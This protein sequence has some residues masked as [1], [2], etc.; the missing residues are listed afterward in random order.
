MTERQIAAAAMEAAEPGIVDCDDCGQQHEAT[1]SHWGRFGEGVVYAVVCPVDDLTG[2]YTSEAV[3]VDDRPKVD[4]AS[5]GLVLRDESGSATG[6]VVALMC[7]SLTWALLAFLLLVWFAP[8]GHAVRI[9]PNS[10]ALTRDYCPNLPGTQSVF[11]LTRHH[12]V[13]KVRQHGPH[14]GEV[15]CRLRKGER[16]TR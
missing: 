9:A 10:P 5:L 8:S 16:G 4:A 2:Y 7:W 14:A 13:V 3:K 11:D 12:V 1:P 15:V 6:K